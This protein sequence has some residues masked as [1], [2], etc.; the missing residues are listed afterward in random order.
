MYCYTRLPSLTAGGTGDNDNDDEEEENNQSS[1]SGS[2]S[3]AAAGGKR[4]NGTS[5]KSSKKTKARIDHCTWQGMLKDAA[6]HF[7]HCTFSGATCGFEGCDVVKARSELVEH[8]HVCVHRT[9][10]CKWDGCVEQL[11]AAE[12]EQH[13]LVCQKR[14]V[15]CPNAES[16]CRSMVYYEKMTQHRAEC[17]YEMCACPFADVGYTARMLRNEIDEHEDDEC[18]RHNRLLLRTVKEQHQAIASLKDQLLP[19]SERIVLRVKHDVL[20]GKESFVPRFADRPGR[21]YSEDHVVRG[22]KASIFVEMKGEDPENYDFYGLFLGLSGGPFPCDVQ[23]TSEVVHH[24][25]KAASAKKHTSTKTFAAYSKWGFT[26]MIS[27]AAVASPDSP[28]VKD[29]YVTFKVTFK[30]V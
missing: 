15:K 24:D 14:V 20:T 23:R 7:N 28:Y 1:S 30:F 12:M 16:G 29:G 5:S 26:Q 25:G 4:K 3:G 8:R 11:K 18:K 19:D 13:Q 2:S 22:Y 10:I 17:L 27:K 21:L 6:E 9:L